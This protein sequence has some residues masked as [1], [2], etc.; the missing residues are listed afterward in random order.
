MKSNLKRMHEIQKNLIE[1]ITADIKDEDD[2]MYMATMLLKHA[3][4]L[5]KGLLT[6][7]QIKSMLGHVADTVEQDFPGFEATKVP[8]KT[9]H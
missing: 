7:E 5:Y 8:K 9:L 4:V 1:H 3:L 6:D 2:H